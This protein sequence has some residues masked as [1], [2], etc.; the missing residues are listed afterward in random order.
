MALWAWHPGIGMQPPLGA[1]F[2]ISR[3]SRFG[4]SNRERGWLC[5]RDKALALVSVPGWNVLSLGPG[6]LAWISALAPHGYR[7]SPQ[8]C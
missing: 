1:G 5:Y 2:G 7:P 8:V 6:G 3:W 4:T